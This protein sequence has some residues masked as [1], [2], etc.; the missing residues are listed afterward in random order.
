[1]TRVKLFA[2]CALAVAACNPL[3]AG[4]PVE[5]V[6]EGC[7][8]E[9]EKYCSQVSPGEGRL[10]ACFYA[11]E[12]KLSTRCVHTLYDAAVAL[13]Q[14]V[15]DLAYLARSCEADI[16]E[17]CADIEPGEGRILNCLSSAGDSLS[18]TCATAFGDVE[19]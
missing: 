3:F 13:E 7:G 1:M 16:D 15:N 4:D 9:I 12:D 17:F 10:L 6:M 8:P 18:E 2:F 14:A 5:K 19:E 11:H